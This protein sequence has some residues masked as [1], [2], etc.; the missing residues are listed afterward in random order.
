MLPDGMDTQVY[1]LDTLNLLMTMICL[2]E[3]MLHGISAKTVILPDTSCFH[4][5]HWP[6]LGLTLD[7]MPD[8]ELIKLIIEHF[9]A[10]NDPNFSCLNIINFLRKIPNIL[11]LMKMYQNYAHER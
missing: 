7:E 10:L 2:I 5:L 3:S 8:Y 6:E 11:K 9:L 4:E 1:N